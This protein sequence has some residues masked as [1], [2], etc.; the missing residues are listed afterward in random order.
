[1]SA[2]KDSARR[3]GAKASILAIVRDQPDDSSYDDV[4][5]ELAF[6]RLV[7]RGLASLEGRRFTTDEMRQRVKSWHG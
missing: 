2:R 4:L 3:D 6:D 5:R 1:M 7:R